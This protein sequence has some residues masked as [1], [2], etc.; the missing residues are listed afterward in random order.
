MLFGKLDE[1]EK[2]FCQEWCK[3]WQ[4]RCK[5]PT[6]VSGGEEVDGR[7]H[8]GPDVDGE[9]EDVEKEELRDPEKMD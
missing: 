9:E 5:A 7:G 2:Y 6:D 4:K 1:N 8:V 3:Y